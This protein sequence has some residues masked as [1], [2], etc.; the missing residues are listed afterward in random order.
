MTLRGR[1]FELLFTIITALLLQDQII[2]EAKRKGGKV[3]RR[4]RGG[5][6][7]SI[8]GDWWIIVLICVGILLF[9]LFWWWYKRNK[10]RENKSSPNNS[11]DSTSD[12][13]GNSVQENPAD[14]SNETEHNEV[15][16][17]IPT[18]W[19]VYQQPE[20]DSGETEPYSTVLGSGGWVQPL[21][22]QQDQNRTGHI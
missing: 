8:G 9:S 7:I 6:K 12:H 13:H 21:E 19:N 11:E 2:V 5:G 20:K 3:G 16:P 10:K 14:H 22:N 4:G 17:E 15:K 1:F 18:V